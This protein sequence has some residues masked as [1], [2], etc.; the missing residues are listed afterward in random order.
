[1]KMPKLEWNWPTV[2]VFGIAVAGLVAGLALVPQP[3]LDK[4][5]AI[6]AGVPWES[7][8]MLLLS[9]GAIGTAALTMGPAAKRKG[10]K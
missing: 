5:F 2:A 3:V 8:L 10:G 4:L 7:I 9:G 6:L 1:M